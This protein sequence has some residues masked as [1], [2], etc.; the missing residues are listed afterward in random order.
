MKPRLLTFFEINL[1]TAET[2]KS[3]RGEQVSFG[4]KVK[5]P[6]DTEVF[7]AKILTA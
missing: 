6:L 3:G 1:F 5:I 4:N 2:P 7:A